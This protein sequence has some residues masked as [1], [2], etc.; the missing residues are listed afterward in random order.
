M[1]KVPK[2][3]ADRLQ[4]QVSRFQR[5]LQG[6]RNRDVNEDD[7]VTIVTDMLAEIFGFDKYTEITSEQAIRGTYC[8][9]AVGIEGTIRFLIEIKAIGLTLKENHLRQ[10]MNYGANQGVSWVVLTNGIIWEIYALKFERPID[11]DL[12]CRF[13][14]LELSGRRSED[15]NLLFLLCREGISKAAIREF[16]KHVQIVNRFMVGAVIQSEPVVR[17]IRRELRRLGEGV[18]VKAEEIECLLPDVLKRDILEGE[19]AEEARARLKKAARKSTK[20][21]KKAAL[22]PASEKTPEA[23]SETTPGSTG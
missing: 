22:A 3:V 21:R 11:C 8:D 16:H 2:R 19:E 17:L 14:L 10:A 1:V 4:K 23:P 15:R 6:A 20:R 18:K 9:L 5:V 13:N 7:T 12:I